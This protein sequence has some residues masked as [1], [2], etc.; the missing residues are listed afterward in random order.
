[1]GERDI[2]DWHGSTTPQREPE[3]T[4][5]ASVP[6]PAS[7]T[8]SAVPS[9][10][11]LAYH[12][13]S[14]PAFLFPLQ[15]QGSFPL[16]LTP[17]SF[18]ALLLSHIEQALCPAPNQ[19]QPGNLPTTPLLTLLADLTLHFARLPLSSS[20]RNPSLLQRREKPGERPIIR[21]HPNRILVKQANKLGRN[22]DPPQLV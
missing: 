16:P 15:F 1:M 6:S 2:L 21:F 22:L 13:M 11:V 19:A 10:P 9:L 17:P 18:P 4:C 8:P 20:R 14:L 12:C 5:L 7:V 3:G